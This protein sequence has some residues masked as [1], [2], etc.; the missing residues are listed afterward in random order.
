MTYL[1]DGLWPENTPYVPELGQ[2][3]DGP[4]EGGADLRPDVRT[5]RI[6]A[7]LFIAAFVVA[8]LWVAWR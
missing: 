6:L 4:P 8:V 2:R 3:G 7:W 1:E 5:P